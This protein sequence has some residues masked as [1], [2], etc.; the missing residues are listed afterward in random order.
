MG[1]D[2]AVPELTQAMT[3]ILSAK[4]IASFA[5]TGLKLIDPQCEY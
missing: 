3:S 1:N 4:T 5:G 2:V